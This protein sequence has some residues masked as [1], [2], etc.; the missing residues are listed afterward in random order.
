MGRRRFLLRTPGLR[1]AMDAPPYRSSINLFYFGH[2]LSK[3]LTALALTAPMPYP[4]EQCHQ[5]KL[6]FKA[7][8]IARR[9]L[10][11]LERA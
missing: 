4:G 10:G 6:N 7:Y 5:L 3:S 1:S 2:L 8:D 9:D 11:Y